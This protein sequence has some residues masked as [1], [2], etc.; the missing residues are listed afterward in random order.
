MSSSWDI[1][2]PMYTVQE[3]AEIEAREDRQRRE[4]E[5]RRGNVNWCNCQRCTLMEKDE[6]NKCCK[7]CHIV[8]KKLAIMTV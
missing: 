4:G 1:E 8:S 7:E 2:D 6:E 5:T 3:L